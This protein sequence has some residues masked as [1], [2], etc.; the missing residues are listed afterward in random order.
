MSQELSIHRFARLNLSKESGSEVLTASVPL[1][2]GE[3]EIA[4]VNKSII[5]LIRNLTG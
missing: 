5:G 4:H 2:V 3:A 1:G